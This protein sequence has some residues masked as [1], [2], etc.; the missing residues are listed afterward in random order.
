MYSSMSYYAR[1]QAERWNKTVA[2][3]WGIWVIISSGSIS[4]WRSRGIITILINLI[5]TGYF[6]LRSGRLQIRKEHAIP[7]FLIILTLV[8]HMLLLYA[9]AHIWSGT[10]HILSIVLMTYFAITNISIR[11]LVQ[12]YC[13]IIEFLCIASLVTYVLQP[14]I[15]QYKHILPRLV[16]VNGEHISNYT[17]VYVSVIK[18][19]GSL[20]N[21]GVFWEPGAF[22][23]FLNLALLFELF[24]IK[25]EKGS[26]SRLALYILTIATT[27]S[28][29]GL[30]NMCLLILAYIFATGINGRQR[31]ILI[32]LILIA[33]GWFLFSTEIISSI[34]Y[35][36]GTET[37]EAASNV[38]SR[39]E[40][41][42][43]DLEIM[44]S[45]PLG[46]GADRYAEELNRIK[47]L[48]NIDF[49]SSS[50]TP[51]ILGASFGIPC[52]IYVLICFAGI[53]RRMSRSAVANM[54]IFVFFVFLFATETFIL[55]PLFYL[56]IFSGAFTN[57]HDWSC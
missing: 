48:K 27:V 14:F 20:R 6:V 51:T 19:E 10:F 41:F 12:Q 39:T 8:T 31:N 35:K 29:A 9:D 34:E 50:C 5:W 23:V 16:S 56:V 33:L 43:I 1:P 18:W 55:Y 17:N 25:R 57:R 26:F 28:T 37:G 45:N 2:L 30:L 15:L 46:I 32:L 36:F 47:A 49:E 42:L 44:A 52:L 4:L 22:Q 40:P 54:F 21:C 11:C 3:L 7:F 13:K 38:T 24:V 53:C